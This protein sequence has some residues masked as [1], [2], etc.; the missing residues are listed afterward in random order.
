MGHQLPLATQ[1]TSVVYPRIPESWLNIGL[2][3]NSIALPSKDRKETTIKTK[4]VI[5]TVDLSTAN[6]LKFILIPLQTLFR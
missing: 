1:N 6:L 5:N 3:E 4:N 2:H